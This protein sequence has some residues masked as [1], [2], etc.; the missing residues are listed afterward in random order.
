MKLKTSPEILNKSK[1]SKIHF[2]DLFLM[3]RRS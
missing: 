1:S 3:T 2:V